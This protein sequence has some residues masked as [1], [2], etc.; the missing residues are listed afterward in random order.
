MHAATPALAARPL[1]ADDEIDA[2]NVSL[3]ERC[4]EVLARETPV[5]SDLRLV[6]SVIR[7]IERARAGRRPLPAGGE[8]STSTTTC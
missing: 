6:V 3:T 1:A 5:A 7:V 8:G 4:Y 2:M